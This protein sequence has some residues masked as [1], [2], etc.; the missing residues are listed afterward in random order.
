[1]LP[2]NVGSKA[3]AGD[4]ASNRPVRG[5][6]TFDITSLPSDIVTLESAVIHTAIAEIGGDPFVQFGSLLIQGL[7]FDYPS[8]AAYDAAPETELGT[9][10]AAPGVHNVG[11]PVSKDVLD[12]LKID[13]AKRDAR[14]NTSRYR[15]LFPT[16]SNSNSTLEEVFVTNDRNVTQLVVKYLHR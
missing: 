1:M 10:I 3:G 14:D 12:A 9:F 15:L 2:S 4:N 8:P 13:Y 6:M 5:F 11:D 7:P 16:A